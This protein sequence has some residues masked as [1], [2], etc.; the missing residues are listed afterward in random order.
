MPIRPNKKALD[1]ENDQKNDQIILD[2][3]LSILKEL[4]EIA[5]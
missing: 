5:I 1:Q 2:K 4:W 3:G